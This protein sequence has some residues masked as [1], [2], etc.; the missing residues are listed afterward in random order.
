MIECL[1]IFL[2]IFHSGLVLFV[3]T[4]WLFPI[5]RK[6]HL[7]IVLLVLLAWLG[8][9]Y[10]KGVIGYCP[11]T[12]WHWEIKRE[13][14]ERSIPNSFIEY[15]AEKLTGRDFRSSTVDL[16]TGIGMTLSVLLSVWVNRK[17][18]LSFIF[19]RKEGR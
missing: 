8:I 15:M 19:D 6:A 10:Y 9:G 14:G 11:L 2:S 12:D 7:I 16:V 18:S 1:D 17:W 13:L 5:A 3:L 4:G